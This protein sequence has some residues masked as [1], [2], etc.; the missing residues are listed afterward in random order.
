MHSDSA[1]EKI[2]VRAAN[3][4]GDAVMSLPAVRAVRE[5]YPASY[6]AVLAKP[7]VAD[8]YTRE[9]SIDALIPYPAARGVKDVAGKL[10]VAR[11]IAREQ[12]DCAILL[13]NAFEA[14]LVAWLARI[15][16]RIG[17]SRD[18]RGFLLT[19]AV[20]VPKQD[21]IPPHQ[22]YYYLELLRRAGVLV[23][24][25]AVPSIEL[26]G[27]AQARKAGASRFG[28]FEMPERVIGVSPGAAYGSAKRWL[29]ERFAEAAAR[30][31]TGARAGVAVFGSPGERALCET[32]AAAVRS[33][34]VQALNLA[35]KTSLG[36]FIELAAAC[37]L[38]LT[39]DSGAMHIASALGV[40]TVAIFGPTDFIATGPTGP[41]TVVVR[42]SVSCSPCLLR[43]CPIDHRCM[44]QV[45]VD[46][47][48]RAALELDAHVFK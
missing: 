34:G 42:E 41:A 2:L 23:S 32:V 36:Q 8:L 43:E 21:E 3:W 16:R 20:A 47:V 6:I 24:L 35:G 1:P 4:V 40:P 28:E 13:P 10:R 48:V 18:A 30:L 17:Y 7:W 38:Y 33:H 5:R 27:A 26:E 11:R 25:P 15:P 37:R 19:D 46:R 44:T 14:A 22:R 31:A 12:F 39:N 45:T 29:P 9:S